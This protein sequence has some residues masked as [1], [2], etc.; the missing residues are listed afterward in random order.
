MLKRFLAQHPTFG[1]KKAPKSLSYQQQSP[2]YW[3]WAYLRRNKDYLACCERGGKGKLAK[4]YA[5][6]GD[7]RGEDF[8]AWWTENDRGATL[9]A[10]KPGVMTLTRLNDKSDWLDDW[11]MEQV[12]VIAIPLTSSKRYLQTRFNRLLTQ[13]HKSKRGRTAKKLEQSTSK[14]PLG[15][16]YTMDNLIKTLTVYDLYMETRNQIPKLKLW[17]IGE[18]LRVVEKAMTKGLT[19]KHD[20]MIRRN[21]MAAS[22]KRY[23]NQAEKMIAN[24]AL[25][26]FPVK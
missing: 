12:L 17:E 23:V 3:W 8:K 16:N 26:K 14:Y 4:L 21:V 18:R 9:F 25:G 6:F 1:T 15:Q 22:V 5:D 10:E 7:V 24:T 2:Y 13:V 20:I 11:A 19:D